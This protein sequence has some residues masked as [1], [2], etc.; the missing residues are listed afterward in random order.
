[1]L[2]RATTVALAAAA[3]VHAVGTI[4]SGGGD[5]KVIPADDGGS[6]RLDAVGSACAGTT[7]AEE[8]VLAPRFG[9]YGAAL[10]RVPVLPR[11]VW[12]GR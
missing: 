2:S 10:G 7:P 3:G 4:K 6:I 9:E 8:R 11:I 12:P 5:P 1:M